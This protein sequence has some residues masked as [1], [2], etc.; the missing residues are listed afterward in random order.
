MEYET[1]ITE[2][3]RE[4]IADELRYE[5]LLGWSLDQLTPMLYNAVE[6]AIKE[7]EEE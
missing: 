4:A 6:D 7:I 1:E 3:L 5:M 2:R